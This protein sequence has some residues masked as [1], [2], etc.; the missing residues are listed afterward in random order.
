LTGS[1]RVSSGAAKERW[2]RS[3]RS[4]PPPGRSSSIATVPQ[5]LFASWFGERPGNVRPRGM[6]PAVKVVMAHA[7]V[8]HG[9]QGGV[10]SHLLRRHVS[11]DTIRLVAAGEVSFVGLR[12]AG[13]LGDEQVPD[14]AD[15]LDPLLR[16]V[17]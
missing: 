4:R 17:G 3:P 11:L 13:E 8:G 6:S 1:R 7:F 9:F 5:S 10:Q 15:Q 12:P 16:R 14:E 2:T